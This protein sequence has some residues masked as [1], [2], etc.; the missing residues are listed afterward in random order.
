MP[1]SNSTVMTMTSRLLSALRLM[2]KD[3]KSEGTDIRNTSISNPK[4]KVSTVTGQRQ[5]TP[6]ELACF[7]MANPDSSGS[8]GFRI[9]QSFLSSLS[10]SLLYS[11]VARPR[12]SGRNLLHTSI[13]SIC[14]SV[15]DDRPVDDKENVDIQ[16]HGS[17]SP[18][19]TQPC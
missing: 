18:P 2:L 9:Y 14:I 6:G 11:M 12:A 7:R 15:H 17:A 8:E 10:P 16:F 13:G 4:Q 19:F 5:A 1:H 3:C